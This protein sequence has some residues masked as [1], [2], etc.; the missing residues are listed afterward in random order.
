[1]DS[2]DTLRPAWIS[3]WVK[4]TREKTASSGL[5]RPSSLRLHPRAFAQGGG[6]RAS[7]YLSR[8]SVVCIGR[9]GFT[10]RTPDT[11]STQ[12][13]LASRPMSKRSASELSV[14]APA[15]K[16]GGDVPPPEETVPD[17]VICMECPKARS[18]ISCCVSGTSASAAPHGP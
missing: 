12:R 7:P 5:L 17:C 6:N 9:S 8:W 11:V 13:R 14:E 18:K 16:K 15:G 10:L 4:Q 2:T 3:I 1:M